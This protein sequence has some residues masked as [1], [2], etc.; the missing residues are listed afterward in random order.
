[1]DA[2]EIKTSLKHAREAI[3]KKEYKDALKHCKAVLSGDGNNYMALVLIAVAAEGLE[4][5]DQALKAYRRAVEA[6]DSQMLAWQGLCSFYEKN[7]KAEF[8]SDQIDVYLK[9]LEFHAS[10][11]EKKIESLQKLVNLIDKSTEKSKL[12]KVIEICR[13]TI[14]E[15]T[16]VE[17][18]T[19]LQV[20][21]IHILQL[22]D[23]DDKVDQVLDLARE[24]LET[25]S[26][27]D[28]DIEQII[29]LHLSY[30]IKRN[31]TE[32]NNVCSVLHK[33]FPQSTAVL[34]YSVI[35]SLD[36][37]LG[38]QKF[39][40][41][42]EVEEK[43]SSYL[44]KIGEE[45]TGTS[46]VARGFLAACGKDYSGSRNILRQVPEA[47]MLV[48]APYF[49]AVTSMY[50]HKYDE[51]FNF[52]KHG[53]KLL[54]RKD[55][56]LTRPS[57]EITSS[58]HL[59]R[60]NAL[61]AVGDKLSLSVAMETIENELDASSD[62]VTLMKGHLHL[63]Q[64]EIEKAKTCVVG[65]S[66]EGIVL[67]GMIALKEN[68]FTEA[69]ERFEKA[70][71]SEP[72]IV[73]HQVNLA[74]CLWKIENRKQECFTMLLKAAKQDPYNSETF[75]YLGHYYSQEAEDSSRSRK[76][77]QK[78][79]DLDPHN[80]S[81]GEALCDIL[82][83]QGEEEQAYAIL[84]NVTKKASAGCA[85]WAWLRLGLYQ[86]KH[87]DPSIAIASFQSAL[88]ADPKD[89]HVWECLG[90]AYLARGSFTASLKAF[91]RASELNPDSMYCLFQ[92]ASI[93]QTLGTYTEAIEEYKLI[94]EKSPNYVPALK[95]VG[96]TYVLVAKSLLSKF[97]HG[98]ARD[99]AQLAVLHLSRAATIRPDLSCLWKLIGDACTILHVLPAENFRFE[100]PDKGVLTKL[101]TLELGSRCYIRALKILPEC[102]SLWHDLG[103]NYIHQ[104]QCSSE[105]SASSLAERSVQ[106][107]K[108]AI[109]LE[110]T[111]HKH[112]NA[113]GYVACLKVYNKPDLAQHCF[114]KS[115]QVE[116]NN[117]IAWTNLAALYLS[118]D[119]VKLAHEAF[120]I[121]QSLE[122]SYVSCWIGQ[123]TIAEVV[124]H[125]DA[126]DLFRHTT[127]L[128][129]HIEGALGYGHWVCTMLQ[130]IDKR[131][132]YMYTYAIE[133]MGAVP[134]ASDA[135]ARYTDRV[136]TNPLAY[137]MYGLLLERQKLYK[138]AAEQFKQAVSLVE[139]EVDKSILPEVMCNYAR[140]LYK[141]GDFQLSCS[142]YNKV[143]GT[144]AFMDL[145]HMGLA[146]YKTGHL[147][148]E[149]FQVYTKAAE[150]AQ[151]DEDKSAVLTALAMVLY[152]F[153]DLGNAKTNLFQ[154][155]QLSN[156]CVAGLKA[157]CA[158]GLIQ[159]DLTLAEAVLQELSSLGDDSSHLYDIALL[160]IGVDMVKGNLIDVKRKLQHLLHRNPCQPRLWHLLSTI[161]LRFF[162]ELGKCAVQA[163]RNSVVIESAVK[164]TDYLLLTLSDMSAG[165]HGNRQNSYDAFL[166][167]QRAVRYN[168]ENLDNWATLASAIH[169]Q[170]VLTPGWNRRLSLL[171]HEYTLLCYIRTQD[172]SLALKF[173]CAKQKIVCT[174]HANM[175]N[176]LME[177]LDELMTE[178]GSEMEVKQMFDMFSNILQDNTGSVAAALDETSSLYYWQILVE[179][180]IRAGLMKDVE[181]TLKHCHYRVAK[182]ANQVFLLKMA[183]L[184]FQQILTSPGNSDHFREVFKETADQ[185][186]TDD[187]DCTVV[188]LMQ[189][190]LNLH[191]NERLAKH[192][193][194]KILDSHVTGSKGHDLSIARQALIH[195]LVNTKKDSDLIQSI[196]DDATTAED[197]ETVNF[198]NKITV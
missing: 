67:E 19:Q 5:Y 179:M 107:L 79:F 165:N 88:R 1:M 31:P 189:G 64:G 100:K 76:C 63:K 86:V 161:L 94:L 109:Q 175:H 81:A 102:S 57:S 134:A 140:L 197:T 190:V 6:D 113:L 171:K 185:L 121:A 46:L 143:A 141:A 10:D 184:A 4:Q 176:E 7:A 137:N 155:S 82:N 98:R 172:V 71:K 69:A 29:S 8:V 174:V 150:M 9:M 170:A 106:A 151:T 123:A 99:T 130:N 33:K 49:Q 47:C 101:E 167:A 183:H 21:L 40:P 154:S 132:T 68:S 191:T 12:E 133:Q 38:E 116:S 18:K 39:D 115:I 58:F 118:K 163:A 126:M 131:D 84:S 181:T 122:P 105:E 66:V 3:R 87:E 187:P 97:F 60:V 142:V 145:C 182:S 125:E 43:I 148:L 192:Q 168:P 120:K 77:Y 14:K 83:Q 108:K 62:I 111:N 50:L 188:N 74:K 13:T 114:I 159:S 158:L 61:L 26:D 15:E 193:L 144:C 36:R 73:S 195:I 53:L 147:E 119:N 117:V 135:L 166:T 59:L 48:C 180:Y 17:R 127:E 24:V 162:P 25:S 110:S 80:D 164:Q 93:K 112:W 198:Y 178:F 95:G 128:G 56:I 28:E 22:S 55:R 20:S 45:A 173:W 2:K 96:E 30:L 152:K 149:S 90:E 44:S 91:T 160:G 196:L 92:M 177:C 32:V 103:V 104:S 42:Q 27:F 70:V 153:G 156:P 75:L 78:A 186:L 23:T 124:G 51:V 65:N 11:K 139:H 129:N 35:V 157:L 89:N 37:S 146:L 34:E 54:Q 41:C 169:A 72:E 136:K 85:K 16:D 194:K 52:C 138:S